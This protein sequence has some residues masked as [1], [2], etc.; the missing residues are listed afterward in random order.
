[1][2]SRWRQE[3]ILLWGRNRAHTHSVYSLQPFT[4]GQAIHG[5]PPQGFTQ[6]GEFSGP[7]KGASF[8]T[9]GVLDRSRFRATVGGLCLRRLGVERLPEL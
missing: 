5:Q 9:F 2:P 8:A 3:A 6:P 7:R 1:M 4:T